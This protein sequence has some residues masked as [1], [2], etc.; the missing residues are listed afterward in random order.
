MRLPPKI[1]NALDYLCT[2]VT[3]IVDVTLAV[4]CFTKLSNDWFTSIAYVAI[5]VMN[6]CLVF[7]SWSRRKFAPW[8]IFA[9]VVGFIDWSFALETSQVKTN[10]TVIVQDSELAR[11]Q[12]QIA[13]STNTINNLHAQYDKAMKRETLDEINNQLT[14]E[15]QKLE[16][17][18]SNYAE[19]YKAVEKKNKTVNISAN[20]VL[21]AV[22]NALKQGKYIPVIFWALIFFGMQLVVVTSIDNKIV[23]APIV[24]KKRVKKKNIEKNVK[25]KDEKPYKNML[26]FSDVTDE[27]YKKAA[28]YSDGSVR[29]PDE[30]AKIL[31]MSREESEAMFLKLYKGY[32]YRGNRY[33]KP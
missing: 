12:G 32:G 27:Q 29:T 6:V 9:I 13:D 10:S 4:I 3:L 24:T 28:E 22:P 5:G 19:R 21:Y 14:A 20:D 26:L 33:V 31:R 30:V 17:Y 7:M 25:P 2:S 1:I 18:N 23:I 15:N 16:Q 11:I 8:I